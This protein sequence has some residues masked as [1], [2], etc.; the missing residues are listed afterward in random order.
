MRVVES[1]FGQA[2]EVPASG[3]F[4]QAVAFDGRRARVEWDGRKD[5]RGY[6]RAEVSQSALDRLGFE[7]S[8]DFAAALRSAGFRASRADLWIDDPERRVTPGRVMQAVAEGQAVT[9]AKPGI[10]IIDHADGRRTYYLGRPT[11]DRRLRVYDKLMPDRT[12]VELQARREAAA[13]AIQ[14]MLAA[15]EADRPAALIG[16]VVR[17]VDF[18]SHKAAGERSR[19]PRLDWWQEVVGDAAKAEAAPSRP[20]LSIPELA[21]WFERSMGR[22][23]AELHDELGDEWLAGVIERGVARL[24][25][26][27]VA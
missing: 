15:A 4:G 6:V 23:L 1:R 8:V 21:A 22:V 12:R 3:F 7:G 11:S 19:A 25:E 13:W 24:E 27:Y 5:A 18:R 26:E 16:Q 9:H 20:R 14:S 10:E 17:F 2:T